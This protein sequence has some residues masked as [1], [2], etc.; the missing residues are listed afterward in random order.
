VVG[1]L[2]IRPAQKDEIEIQK[3]L[4]K[5]SFGDEDRYIDLYFRYKYQAD[6][7]MLLFKDNNLASMLTMFPLYV[8]TPDNEKFKAA[9]FYGIATDPQ[10]QGYGFAT[11][12]INFCNDF[13]AKQNIPLTLLVPASKNLFGFYYKLGY[14]ANFYLRENVLTSDFINRP[15]THADY[16]CSIVPA[17]P[18]EYNSRREELLEGKLHVAYHA[19]DIFYQKRL[20]QASGA[21][22][23]TVDFADACGCVVVERAN[24]LKVV[25]KELL[26]PEYYLPTVLKKII[27]MLP[28]VEYVVR[29]PC[30][31]NQPGENIFKPFGM[32]RCNDMDL[33][34]SLED[35]GYLGLAFD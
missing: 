26:V 30:F 6:R 4:W 23:F 18:E 8:S 5:K 27:S 2:E 14:R 28:S 21:D 35:S 17:S 13:L 1:L 15:A 25:I 24:P 12:L 7:T 33:A 29:T 10:Y 9:M 31:I 19:E 20:S 11:K 22:I 3:N 34:K 16:E 32:L